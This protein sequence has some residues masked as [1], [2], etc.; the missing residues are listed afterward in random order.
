MNMFLY[1]DAYCMTNIK[2]QNQS[3]GI[4]FNGITHK[5]PLRERHLVMGTHI[6]MV[7]TPKQ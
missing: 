3:S 7:H 1:I 5:H 6:D 4:Q 2:D